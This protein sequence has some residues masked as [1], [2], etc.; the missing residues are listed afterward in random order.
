MRLHKEVAPKI[1]ELSAS[2]RTVLED[3]E[4]VLFGQR[5]RGGS[6]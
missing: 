1:L 2:I 6:L 5:V 3:G 4:S